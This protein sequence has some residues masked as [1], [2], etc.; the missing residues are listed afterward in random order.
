MVSEIKK[1]SINLQFFGPIVGIVGKRSDQISISQDQTRLIDVIHAM[2]MRYGETFE[3]IA[4]KN[5]ELNSGLI[6]FVNGRHLI[7]SRHKL[8]LSEENEMQ[9]MIASQ[10]KGG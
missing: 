8:E 2:C 9:F 6:V 5:E 10:M 4:L 7:D 3:E 1:N